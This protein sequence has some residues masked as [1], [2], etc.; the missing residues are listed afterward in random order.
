MPS[1][2][3]QELAKEAA[4]SPR[5]SAKSPLFFITE[6]GSTHTGENLG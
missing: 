4:T 2:E 6:F 3:A 1:L 5:P